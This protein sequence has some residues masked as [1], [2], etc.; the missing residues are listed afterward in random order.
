DARGLRLAQRLA[1]P[2]DVC[3]GRAGERAD[4]HV[5]AEVG[6]LAD[7]LEVA[8]GGR[9]EAGLADVDLHLLQEFGEFELLADGH[10][11][12]GRLLAVAHGGVE[13]QDA[14]LARVF[15]SCLGVG[16]GNR[17][18]RSS[19]RVLSRKIRPLDASGAVYAA[20]KW[21]AQGLLRSP[22]RRSDA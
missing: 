18:L 16:H 21:R 12:A 17:V 13:D 7:A 1:C 3:E 8:F 15:V 20:A 19:L 14:V 4:R 9:G 11:G 22:C 10:P 5:L 2:V 6:D